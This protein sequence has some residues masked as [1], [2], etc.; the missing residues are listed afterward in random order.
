MRSTAL[1]VAA[2]AL[3]VAWRKQAAP[4]AP[5]I[6]AGF[7]ATFA[8]WALLAL[9]SLAW[10][11]DPRYTLGE[12][13]NETFY[14]VLAVAVF[15]LLAVEQPNRWRLWCTALLAGTL[16]L[17]LLHMAQ[18]AFVFTL[19]RHTVFEQRGPWSTHLVLIA[20]LVLALAWRPPWG[21]GRG[22]ALGAGAMALLLY[23]AW[24]TENR[25]V[26]VALAAQF[27]IAATLRPPPPS[28]S[29]PPR[30]PRPARLPP[31]RPA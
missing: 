10:S 17:F 2:L 5:R 9:A 4:F 6:P 20:P 30:H 25:I 13:R 18:R 3:A 14:A 15:F 11:V 16:A 12:L 27:L 21:G 23:A 29:R 28:Q 7:A 24:E 19:T 22:V 8:A 26:W 1:I 31:R